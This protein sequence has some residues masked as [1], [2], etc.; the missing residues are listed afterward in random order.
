MEFY[1][2]TQDR[3]WTLPLFHTVTDRATAFL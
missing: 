1:I 3:I 2:L